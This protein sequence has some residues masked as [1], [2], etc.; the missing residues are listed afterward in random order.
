MEKQM[1]SK[2]FSFISLAT[3]GYCFFIATQNSGKDKNKNLDFVTESE[4][5]SNSN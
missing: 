5:K 1:E 2:S 3:I 4:D